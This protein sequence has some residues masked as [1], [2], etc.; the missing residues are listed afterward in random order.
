MGFVT[1]NSI[2]IQIEIQIGPYFRRAAPKVI[3]SIV[4]RRRRGKLFVCSFSD[5]AR[6]ARFRASARFFVGVVAAAAR[7]FGRVWFFVL[8]FAG[9][10]RTSFPLAALEGGT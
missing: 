1:K 6:C 9:R 8:I 7:L 2:I 10:S 4:A 5:C 3:P